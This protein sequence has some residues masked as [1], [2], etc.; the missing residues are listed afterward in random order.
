MHNYLSPCFPGYREAQMVDGVPI[1]DQLGF[2]EPLHA[3]VRD[4]SYGWQWS[5][6]QEYR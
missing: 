2:Y 5:E 3:H 1:A 4:S 6:P